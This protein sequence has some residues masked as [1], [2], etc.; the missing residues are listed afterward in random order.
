[1]PAAASAVLV[2]ARARSAVKPAIRWVAALPWRLTAHPRRAPIIGTMPGSDGLIG[3]DV[4]LG[5]L[6]IAADAVA[7][8]RPRAV[9]ITGESGIGKTALVEAFIADLRTRGWATATG[10]AVR[11][12]GGAPPY[13]PF[14]EVL[15]ALL[16]SLEPAR[17]RVVLGAVRDELG[18][19][20]PGIVPAPA[21]ATT[22]DGPGSVAS[23]SDPLRRAR[24]FEAMLDIGERLAAERPVAIVIEDVQWIDAASADLLR[25]LVDRAEVGRLLLVVTART[26]DLDAARTRHLLTDVTHRRGTDWIELDR[27]DRADI[28]RLLRGQLGVAPASALVDDITRRSGGNPLIVEELAMAY[29][30]GTGLSAGLRES[31]LARVADLPSSASLVLRAAALITEPLDE[32]RLAAVTGL[33]PAVTANAIHAL[34]DAQVLVLRDDGGGRWPD[35]RHAILREVIAD[36]LLPAERRR[37]HRAVA[38]AAEIHPDVAAISPA[39]AAHHW[40]AAGDTERAGAAALVAHQ[41]ALAVGAYDEALRWGGAALE[42][43]PASPDPGERVALLRSV[44]SA[45]LLAGEPRQA[46]DH[47]LEALAAMQPDTERAVRYETR[48]LFRVAAFAAGDPAAALADATA[49]VAEIAVVPP[50]TFR[51]EALAH[52]AAL[53]LAR[54][55]WPA[56]RHLAEEAVAISVAVGTPSPVALSTGVLGLAMVELGEVEPGLAA[57]RHACLM[58]DAAGA[59]GYDLAYRRLVGLEARLGRYEDVLETARR[60]R[61]TAAAAGLARTLGRSLNADEADALVQLGRWREAEVLLEPALAEEPDD[62]DADRLRVA[63]ARLRL[64]RDGPAAARA[65]IERAITESDAPG[66]GREERSGGSVAAVRR[67]WLAAIELAAETAILDHRPQV[68]LRGL[69]IALGA[70]SAGDLPVG[71]VES[72]VALE[73]AAA[74]ALWAATEP[75][76]TADGATPEEV[77]VEVRRRV[78]RPVGPFGGYLRALTARVARDGRA[79]ATTWHATAL[80]MS[81]LGLGWWAGWAHLFAA[82]AEASQGRRQEAAAAIAAAWL[83]ATGLG[84]APLRGAVDRLAR[85]LGL[86]LPRTAGGGIAAATGDAVADTSSHGL[87]EREREVLELLVEGFTNREIAER[88][89]ISHKTASVH[90]SNIL[91]KLEVENRTEAAAVAVRLGLTGRSR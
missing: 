39:S 27:L 75:R 54:R 83:T 19:L 84:S 20:L 74:L 78:G 87:T 76:P 42:H 61:E 33:D 71:L 62:D 47:C 58:A 43:V 49:V 67:S 23:R 22:P 24:L 91:G 28:A 59:R 60:G 16:R 63:L 69:D 90:V 3:R 86:P 5:R 34:L 79:A 7:S 4:P 21:T 8:G 50:D 51:A 66:R 32:S 88:L 52:L 29:T 55:D 48:G 31:V 25:F 82:E 65:E 89:G 77:L 6:R 44:A 10:R 80:E 38:E 26:D 53:A 30:Q 45:A 36:T 15:E 57:V 2:A 72:G 37:L 11:M 81:G 40:T 64:R 1:M 46:A 12:D 85:R 9:L 56:A 73:P 13:L 17:A 68:A 41:A 18:A 35:F 70:V 14:V